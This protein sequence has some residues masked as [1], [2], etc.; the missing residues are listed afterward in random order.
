MNTYLIDILKI[1]EEHTDENNPLSQQEILKLMQRKHPSIDRKAIKR[2]LD[3]LIELDYYDINYN[4]TQRKDKDGEEITVYTDWYLNKDFTDAELHILIDGLLYSKYIPYSQCKELVKKLNKQASKSFR[5]KVK[6]PEN[7][8]E[9]KELLFNIEVINETISKGRRVSF[10]FC[11]Y[12]T[13]KKQ[14]VVIDA[15]GQP[16][17]YTVSPYEI[18]VTNARYYLICSHG[19]GGLFHYRLDYIRNAKIIED[20]KIRPLRDIEG[21]GRGLDLARYMKEHIYMYSGESGLVSFR[22]D[23]SIIGHII[24]WFGKDIVFTEIKENSIVA[25]VRVNLNAMLYWALQYGNSVEILTPEPL[26][27]KVREAV[28]GMWEKYK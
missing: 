28:E 17:T 10:Q 1:L 4:E 13:N 14:R 8:P 27:D 26:R 11:E 3:K 5:S 16:R 9:N 23:R 6:L 22:A 25:S 12:D 7:E 24:D 20:K 19:K 21:H 18:V 2:N 15:E